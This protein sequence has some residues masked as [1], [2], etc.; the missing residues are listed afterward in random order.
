MGHWSF[1]LVWTVF[2]IDRK[3]AQKRKTTRKAPSAPVGSQGRTKPAPCAAAC[4]AT[5]NG[6][7]TARDT[8][9]LG[10]HLMH[11][12]NESLSDRANNTKKQKNR[13]SS[14]RSC[15]WQRHRCRSRRH[16]Y[17]HSQ[18]CRLFCTRCGWKVARP[19]WC[20]SRRGARRRLSSKVSQASQIGGKR[21]GR[22]GPI[23]GYR[24]SVW[25]PPLLD[26][27]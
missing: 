25:C 2:F 12:G 20:R 27:V 3:E 9:H 5:T 13:K 22:K 1:R 24:W 7:F 18:R 6:G 11:R 21:F 26:T 14:R 8:S 15:Q 23:V 19:P 10:S 4:A 17:G 16:G